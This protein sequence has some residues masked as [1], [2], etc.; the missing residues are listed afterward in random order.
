MVVNQVQRRGPMD[1]TNRSKRGRT[2]VIS[3]QTQ[4]SGVWM[5]GVLVGGVNIHQSRCQLFQIPFYQAQATA[6]LMETK[7]NNQSNNRVLELVV[8]PLVTSQNLT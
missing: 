4:V 7:L 5:G 3:F 2:R 6:Q 1:S 8:Q